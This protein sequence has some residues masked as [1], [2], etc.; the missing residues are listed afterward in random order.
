MCSRV[1]KY[2]NFE[3]FDV[4]LKTDTGNSLDIYQTTQGAYIGS[5]CKQSEKI[6]LDWFIFVLHLDDVAIDSYKDIHPDGASQRNSLL[7][8]L[9]D[10]I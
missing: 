7:E 1:R 10:Y 4:P 2:L 8:T 3:R 5:F 6:S 9:I